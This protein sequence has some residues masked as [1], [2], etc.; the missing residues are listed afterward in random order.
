MNKDGY[1]QIK[2]TDKEAWG[3]VYDY[4]ERSFEYRESVRAV[5]TDEKGLVALQ[6]VAKHGVYTLPGGGIEYG[7]TIE[8]ALHR[9]I[10]EEVGAT[11]ETYRKVGEILE[12]RYK[13]DADFGKIQLN[14]AFICS[15]KAILA[16][17]QLTPNEIVAGSSLL[18]VS[19]AEAVRK[20]EN[21]PKDLEDFARFAQLR[22]LEILSEYT[23]SHYQS[24]SLSHQ[25]TGLSRQLS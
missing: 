11:I 15:F 1:I 3:K 25:K 8:E 24:I 17:P 22:D 2:Y 5:V 13:P 4:S 18:W 9:E 6:H 21:L 7:E 14:H 20:I 12:I 10:K 16:A 23:K 19:Y